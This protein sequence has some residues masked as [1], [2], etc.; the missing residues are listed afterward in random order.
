MSDCTNI[1]DCEKHADKV[2][3]PNRFTFEEMCN[4]KMALHLAPGYIEDFMESSK[5]SY[6]SLEQSQKVFYNKGEEL[7]A[8]MEELESKVNN[9]ISMAIMQSEG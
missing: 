3:C 2:Y 8:K 6:E 7:M 4:I 5:D 1:K 9:L